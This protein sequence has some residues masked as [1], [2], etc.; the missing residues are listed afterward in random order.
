MVKTTTSEVTTEN[1][2]VKTTTSEV[3]T[4][5]EVVKTTTGETTME[6]EVAQTTTNEKTEGDRTPSDNVTSFDLDVSDNP[7][8]LTPQPIQSPPKTPEL[9]PIVVGYN[10]RKKGRYNLR[11]NPRPNVDPDFR[12]LDSATTENLSQ[13]QN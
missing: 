7:Y 1:E 11:P 6:N 9:P 3:T 8:I 4:E 12:M 10:P 13:T 5:N 2:V